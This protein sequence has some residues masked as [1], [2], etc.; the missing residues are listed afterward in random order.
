M[1]RLEKDIKDD[2]IMAS[3]NIYQI[4]KCKNAERDKNQNHVECIWRHLK[5]L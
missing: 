1:T 4:F 3:I 5:N 2:Q